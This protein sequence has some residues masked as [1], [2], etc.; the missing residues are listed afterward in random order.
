[1]MANT[2]A[3][4]RAPVGDELIDVTPVAEGFCFPGRVLLPAR[5]GPIASLGRPDR[6]PGGA[7]VA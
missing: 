7:W 3:G 4:A 2:Q 1:M 5:H 6:A